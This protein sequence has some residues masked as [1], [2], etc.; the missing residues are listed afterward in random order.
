MPGV[1]FIFTSLEFDD[2]ISYLSKFFNNTASI[3]ALLLALYTSIST[4]AAP[5]LKVGTVADTN[6]HAV[7]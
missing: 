1:K 4:S 6:C 3:V 5:V 2:D 7:L